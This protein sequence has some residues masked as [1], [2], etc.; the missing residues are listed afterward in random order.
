MSELKANP[1]KVRI[2]LKRYEES[3]HLWS[4][5]QVF[6]LSW[7]SFNEVDVSHGHL[8]NFLYIIYI[9][10]KEKENA[11]FSRQFHFLNIS[12][13][14]KNLKKVP[15]WPLGFIVVYNFVKQSFPE[16]FTVLEI[17]GVDRLP[18]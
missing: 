1:T 9:L 2:P 14:K 8:P 11:A 15:A 17:Q 3:C 13:K 7:I 18:L 6:S 10:E 12:E 4:H 5:V 16:F